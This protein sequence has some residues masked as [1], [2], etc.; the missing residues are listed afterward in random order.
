MGSLPD[1]VN[2]ICGLIALAQKLGLGAG[3][4]GFVVED[5]QGLEV[6]QL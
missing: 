5:L 3:R 4:D 6:E 2:T 1:S